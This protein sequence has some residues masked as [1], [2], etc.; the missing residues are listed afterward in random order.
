[1]AILGND[2]ELSRHLFFFPLFPFD[3]DEVHR[4]FSFLLFFARGGRSLSLLSMYNISF[5]AVVQTLGI[6]T[7]GSILLPLLLYSLLSAR[8][9]RRQLFFFGR[10]GG[11]TLCKES[12]SRQSGKSGF[13]WTNHLTSITNPRLEWPARNKC[14]RN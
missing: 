6:R 12:S 7:K 11:W 1:M 13:S 4:S 14:E 5:H 9:Y 2:I 10:V 3:A 8:H